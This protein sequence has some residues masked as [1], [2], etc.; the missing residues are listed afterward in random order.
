MEHFD[1]ILYTE[2]K[3]KC[4]CVLGQELNLDI[5]H[6]SFV[7]W[8]EYEIFRHTYYI[9]YIFDLNS[10]HENFRTHHIKIKKAKEKKT[11]FLFRQFIMHKRILLCVCVC[12]SNVVAVVLRWYH[13]CSSLC[14][15]HSETNGIFGKISSVTETKNNRTRGRRKKWNIALTKMKIGRS[16]PNEAPNV[17][18]V[19]AAGKIQHRILHHSLNEKKKEN[20]EYI[21]VVFSF[22]RSE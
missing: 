4:M 16:C 18:H 13:F 15:L 12:V 14:W 22:F 10:M 6:F 9:H 11:Y 3:M 2:S 8:S 1:R 20:K 17:F 5:L 7:H 19:G 21:F